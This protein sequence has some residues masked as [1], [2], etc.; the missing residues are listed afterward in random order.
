MTN[1][2]GCFSERNCEKYI[3]KTDVIDLN[4]CPCGA[5]LIKVVCKD[6]C[7]DFFNFYKGYY[8]DQ[9]LTRV[10]WIKKYEYK[11]NDNIKVTYD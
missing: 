2:K 11:E 9:Y 1:C 8:K 5:C 7:E 3:S 4:K 6:P 10:W